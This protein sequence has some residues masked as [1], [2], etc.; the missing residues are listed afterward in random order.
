MFQHVS[1]QEVQ[2]F[3]D[4]QYLQESVYDEMGLTLVERSKLKY[5]ISTH[6]MS[7]ADTKRPSE[8]HSG[9]AVEMG[10]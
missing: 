10:M 8:K 2:C 4:F 7:S 1:A 9:T 6:H 5:F 3:E